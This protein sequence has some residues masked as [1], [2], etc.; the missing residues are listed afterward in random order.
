MKVPGYNP[1]RDAFG[2]YTHIYIY[3]YMGSEGYLGLGVGLVRRLSSCNTLRVVN[4]S[5]TLKEFQQ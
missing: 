2:S 3:V 1:A 4:I 5:N